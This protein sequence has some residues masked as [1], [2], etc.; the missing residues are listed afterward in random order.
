[1]HA[2]RE[3]RIEIARPTHV[4]NACRMQSLTELLDEKGLIHK[5]EIKIRFHAI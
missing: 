1:M 2:L 3:N 5:H 4:K